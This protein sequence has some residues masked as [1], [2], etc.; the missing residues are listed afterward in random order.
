M[1]NVLDGLK[2]ESSGNL[3]GRPHFLGKASGDQ[4]IP[5]GTTWSGLRGLDP[6]SPSRDCGAPGGSLP[7]LDFEGQE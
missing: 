3:A 6:S 5:R 7:I 4:G 1:T 2:T